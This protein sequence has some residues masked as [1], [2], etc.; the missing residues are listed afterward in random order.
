[1]LVHQLSSGCRLVLARCAVGWYCFSLKTNNLL[2]LEM[3]GEPENQNRR[4]ADSKTQNNELI[5]SKTLHRAG[6]KCRVG[7]WL[8][9][10]MSPVIIYIVIY[11][12]VIFNT[13]IAALQNCTKKYVGFMLL[14]L[15]IYPDIYIIA[16]AIKS[17]RLY[18]IMILV[19]LM[20]W[21][22]FNQENIY[23]IDVCAWDIDR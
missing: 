8:S 15:H 13:L 10:R 11:P 1:M 2:C 16:N 21:S 12:L 20:H 17:V 18:E 22:Y 14:C 19:V 23:C 7:W 5:D 4:V 3:S 9:L 6:K